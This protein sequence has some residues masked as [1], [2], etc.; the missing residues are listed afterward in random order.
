MR[1]LRHLAAPAAVLAALA[2]G[3]CQASDD[4]STGPS[5]TTS[6]AGPT[7]VATDASGDPSGSATAGLDPATGVRLTM[8]HVSVRAPGGWRRMDELVSTQVAAGDPDSVSIVTL[9]EDDG[10][11]SDDSASEFGDDAL[12]VARRIYPLS[13]KKLSTVVVDGREMY[14]IAGKVQPLNWMEEFGAI[15]D[16]RSVILR[17]QLP[18]RTPPAQRT[19]IVDS[20]L[21]S[22]RWQ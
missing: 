5:P 4:P 8:P 15:V 6:A 10:F 2:V 13:P 1:H 7:D 20:V 9:G 21:A 17:F 11:G 3:G 16:D 14:H 12:K 22:L 18:V 19:A